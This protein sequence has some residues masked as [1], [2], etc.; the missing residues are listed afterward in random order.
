MQ[1]RTSF[2]IA[3][4]VQSVMNADL[5]L[6]LDQGR[7]VQRGTHSELMAQEGFYR[8]IYDM[9]AR[10]EDELER[11]MADV[12]RQTSEVWETS[13]VLKGQEVACV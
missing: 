13:E 5:I 1:G 9:Q 3:H 10:V 6:V 2:I 7:I 8:R 11:E 4:R 12:E